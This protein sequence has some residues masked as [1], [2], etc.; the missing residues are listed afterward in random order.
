MVM[1]LLSRI[2]PVDEPRVVAAI[3]AAELRTSGEVRVF[4]SS[5]K[6]ESPVDAAGEQFVRLG[7]D[8]TAARNGVLIYVAPASH[9]FAVV[10]DKGVHEKC[11]ET[12][13]REL[14]DAMS[15]RFK[16]G[17]F[18]GGLV[19]GIERAGELLARHFPRHPDDRN[20][21]PDSIEQGH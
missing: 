1:S 5:R 14:A 15:A 12:F 3:A 10:G 16:A 6:I 9:T 4:I 19:L 2:P 21:L 20:E 17:D 11:G 13:W 8:R 7:M 18:T